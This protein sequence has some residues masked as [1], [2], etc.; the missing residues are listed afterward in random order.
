M[1]L[2]DLA[3]RRAKPGDKPLKLSDGGGLYLLL[4]PTG[5][6]YWRWKYR[7]TGKEK[8]LALGIYPDVPLWGH[9]E[10]ARSGFNGYCRPRRLTRRAGK[11]S[12]CPTPNGVERFSAS[13]NAAIPLFV[14]WLNLLGHG[15]ACL[16]RARWRIY[17]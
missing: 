17:E 11:V 1:P 3:I 9:A 10:L 15:R 8:P 7:I 6:R 13:V 4:Q 2:S 14:I 16:E 12:D 5:A